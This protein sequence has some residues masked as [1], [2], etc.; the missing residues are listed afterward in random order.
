MK[1]WW[2]SGRRSQRRRRRRKK[3]SHAKVRSTTQRRVPSPEPLSVSRWAMIGWPG[4]TRMSTPAG[5]RD[6]APRPGSERLRA[7]RAGARRIRRRPGARQSRCTNP[8]APSRR[9]QQTMRGP[10]RRADAMR[11]PQLARRR[12]RIGHNGEATAQRCL[13][14]RSHCHGWTLPPHRGSSPWRQHAHSSTQARKHSRPLDQHVNIA[15]RSMQTTGM[16][17]LLEVSVR[18]RS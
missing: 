17:L 12:R 3:C 7:R 13:I 5:A 18:G 9:M 4:A 14:G 8:L 6:T 15:P 10:R 16:K 2:S 1:A 11:D